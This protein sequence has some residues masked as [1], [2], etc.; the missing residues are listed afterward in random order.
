MPS[1]PGV[2]ALVKQVPTEGDLPAELSCA[3]FTGLY[4]T[5]LA[6]TAVFRSLGAEMREI[7]ITACKPATADSAA[8]RVVI[9]KGPFAES[10]D[11]AGTVYRRGVRT[12]VSAAQWDEL[13][14][15]V[16]APQFVF[17]EDQCFCEA[18]AASQSCGC[19]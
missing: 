14:R 19:G 4:V 9:Y 10:A 13:A 6:E 16:A 8:T 2:A 11:D 18:G 3:G 1:L 12:T 5:K 17:V 15:S 7:K